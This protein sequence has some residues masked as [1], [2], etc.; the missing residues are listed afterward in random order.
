MTGCLTDARDLTQRLDDAVV[1]LVP[2]VAALL[3][4]LSS[5]GEL[6]TRTE[7][8]I[9]ILTVPLRFPD[10]IG[11]GSIVARVFR[12]R[13]SVRVD[14]EIVH[15]RVLA[16]AAGVPS[17]R[18]CFLNDFVTSVALGPEAEALPPEFVRQVLTGVRNATAAVESHNKRHPEPWGQVRVVAV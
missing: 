14:L 11:R 4:R 10:G 3:E 17:Q 8:R 15:N 16:N 7:H 5:S 6:V 1:R 18:P 9:Q 12:Y 2:S 13:T